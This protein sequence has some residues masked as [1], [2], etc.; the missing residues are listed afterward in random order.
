MTDIMAEDGLFEMEKPPPVSLADRFGVPPFS[1]LD[2]RQ[3]VWQE[4]RARW[5]SIGIES[6]LGRDNDLLSGKN[7]AYG[8]SKIL[9]D[10]EGNF[11]YAGKQIEPEQQGCLCTHPAEAHT[12]DGFCTVCA[13]C[14]EYRPTNKAN[15]YA[16]GAKAISTPD[17]L[18]YEI[19]QGATSVFDPVLCELAYRWFTAPG[20][21]ILDPFAGGSVRGVVA[22]TLGRPYLGIDLRAEQIEANKAQASLVPA[23]FPRP[24]W[25]AGDSR[26][27]L[28]RAPANSVDFVWSCPPYADLEVY[29]SDPRD[30]STMEYQ[31]FLTA[32]DEIVFKACKALREDR[33]AAWVI[34]DVRDKNGHYRGLVHDAV[35][36]FRKAGLHF[37]NDAIVLDPVGTAAVRAGRIFN[38]GR[39]LVRMHQHLLV[40]VKGDAKRATRLITEGADR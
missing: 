20:M 23:G 3:G 16:Y 29:S 6:E 40:F 33:F 19:A 30:L 24:Q 7:A 38:G 36:S 32:H 22:G 11:Q 28:A 39:K 17:G 18:V 35:R 27:L 12:A 13:T 31:E 9:K 26:D 8:A 5:L 21:R 1:I 15:H 34:S 2:R 25:R 4:R 37:Y 10:D 14:T